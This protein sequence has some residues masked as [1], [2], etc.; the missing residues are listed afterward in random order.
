MKPDISIVSRKWLSPKGLDSTEYL[1]TGIDDTSWG[2]EIALELGTANGKAT[3]DFTHLTDKASRRAAIAKFS[4]IQ[5]E[6]T[7]LI[8][9]L[10]DYKE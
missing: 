5:R 10:N 6:V 7:K 3:I 2:L 4:I 1:Y 8:T 9:Y